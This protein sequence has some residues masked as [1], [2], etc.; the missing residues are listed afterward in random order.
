MA[1][2]DSFDFLDQICPE[3]VFSVENKKFKHRHWLLHIILG[4]NL[5]KK[6]IVRRQMEKGEHHQWIVHIWISLSPKFQLEL[7][8]LIF[9]TKFVEKGYFWFKTKKSRFCVGP[10]SLLAVLN[11]S[12]WGW[13]T[14][15]YFNVS[16][17]SSHRDKNT[18]IMY[19]IVL[20]SKVK[21]WFLLKIHIHQV[22]NG[23][24]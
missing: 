10:W 6:D 20:V 2:T 21:S 7:T 22:R 14:Q 1:E 16:S 23:H 24:N 18:V 11:F 17:P 19:L 12:A 8:I 5:P 4:Q 9:W 15:R 3:G 13:Q